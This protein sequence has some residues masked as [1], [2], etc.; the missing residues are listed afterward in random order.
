MKSARGYIIIVFQTLFYLTSGAVLVQ[1]QR[2]SDP[3]HL[4]LE[5]IDD[6]TGRLDNGAMIHFFNR[7]SDGVIP[8]GSLSV[9]AAGAIFHVTPRNEAFIRCTSSDGS[10]KSQFLA[11]AG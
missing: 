6:L 2:A 7:A 5:C 1:F 8:H 4:T 10:G 3:N 9:G 11:I